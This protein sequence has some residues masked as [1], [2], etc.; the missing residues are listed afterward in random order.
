[1]SKHTYIIAARNDAFGTEG[2]TAYV[3]TERGARRAAN[4]IARLAGHG[5]TAV[6]HLWTES[7][8]PAI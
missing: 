6:V 8:T 2:S 1:M 4:K 7:Y 3:G 5:W